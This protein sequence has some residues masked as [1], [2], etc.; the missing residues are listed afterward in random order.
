MPRV[1]HFEFAADNP[2]RAA[3]FYTRVFGWTIKKWDGP[4]DY[5]LVSTGEEQPGINGGLTRRQGPQNVVNTVDVPSVDEFTAKITKNGG[6]VVQGKMA[7]PGVGYLAMC[8]DTEGNI[9]GIMQSDEKA[10]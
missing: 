4:M 9:F 3:Q 6:K 7:I 2:D 8:Q 5:W 10:E 1:V